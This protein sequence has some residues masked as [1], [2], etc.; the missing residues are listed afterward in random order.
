MVPVFRRSVSSPDGAGRPG[1]RVDRPPVE[2]FTGACRPC[3]SRPCGAGRGATG[4]LAYSETDSDRAARAARCSG[5]IGGSLRHRRSRALGRDRSR[6]GARPGFRAL[7]LLAP[8]EADRGEPLQ[9]R[10]A[11]L[12]R[13]GV[14]PPRPARAR[15]WFCAGIGSSSMRGMRGARSAGRSA[16]GGMNGVSGSAERRRGFG[17]RSRPARRTASASARDRPDRHVLDRGD[18]RPRQPAAAPAAGLGRPAQPR[19]PARPRGAPDRCARG[20]PRVRPCAACWR[21][22]SGVSSARREAAA[23]ACGAGCGATAC[24]GARVG[25]M[26]RRQRDVDAGRDDRHANDAVEAFVEGRA[27]DDVGVAV[28]LLADAGRGF[29]D[30]VE[31][32][33]PCRR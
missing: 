15:I 32:R 3:W 33:G 26:L 25:W 12:L 9:Q 29:V 18:R 31:R 20:V 30:L 24:R 5:G 22:A 2:L 28:D 7:L 21:A 10:H 13:G 27:D 8:A 23:T 1:F 19:A 16:C 4:R 6:P 17:D 11:L 14:R